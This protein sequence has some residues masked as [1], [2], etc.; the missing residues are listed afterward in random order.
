V[1]HQGKLLVFGAGGHGKVVADVARSA[2]WE[3]AGFVDDA[4]ERDGTAIWG[5][6]VRSLARLQRE[7][8]ELAGAAF[9]LG[10]GDNGARGRCHARLRQAGLTVVSLVHAS[11]TVAPTAVLGEG[12]VVM[13]KAA[14]NPDA[15]L[16]L[17]CIVNTGAVVEHDCLLGDYVHLS[18]T[19][20]LGG[21]VTIGPRAHLGLGA[22][23]LP[24]LRVGAD[25]RVGAGAAAIRDVAD[26]DTVVGV[27]ARPILKGRPHT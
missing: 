6:P 3:L 5:L 26:G 4:P 21:G 18:P 23:A 10:V 8:P 24:G 17:G 2:G 27:P 1:S 9:A 22:V 14:V 13:A 25:A 12:T 7:A 19:A 16:G 11:A 20:A 15:R